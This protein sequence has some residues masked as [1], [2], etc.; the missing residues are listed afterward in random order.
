MSVNDRTTTGLVVCGV[1]VK[2][3]FADRFWSKVDQ[4]SAEGCWPWMASRKLPSGYG[5]FS[6]GGRPLRVHRISWEL[7]AGPIP[8][9][10]KVLHCC[11]YPPCL[12][13]DEPG[14]Y[15]LNGIHYPRNGHLFLAEHDVNMQDMGAKGRQKYQIH[16][17][18]APRGDAHHARRTPSVMA[19]GEANGNARLTE[20]SVRAIRSR[21]PKECAAALAQEFEVDYT[22]IRRIVRLDT[23]RH[24][25]GATL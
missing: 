22:T 10:H 24:I 21:W 23:W 13:N 2:P 17:Q 4:S 15:E 19:R 5:Q 20:D 1:Q 6:L 3:N 16:P 14:T 7:V 11:D 12:R 25:S 9:G 8:D 18:L